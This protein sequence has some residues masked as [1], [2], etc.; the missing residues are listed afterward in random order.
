MTF[1][2]DILQPPPKQ[3]A[4]A[5]EIYRWNYRVFELLNGIRTLLASGIESVPVGVITAGTVQEAITQTASQLSSK[6]DSAHDH[7]GGDGGQIDHTTLSNIGTNTHALIDTH[8][9]AAVPHSG[10][11]QT[12][13]KDAASG[14][15]GLSAA[16]RITKGS[17]TTDDH[18]VDAATKGLVLKD[19]QATPHYWR[20]TVNNA[21]ALVIADLGVTKP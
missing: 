1:R 6:V 13:R 14:Y 16:S 7:N 4:G 8:I 3:N 2:A 9:A 10:H 20:V 15:A 5:E 19:T 18:I 12:T 17:D 11:E 21:G